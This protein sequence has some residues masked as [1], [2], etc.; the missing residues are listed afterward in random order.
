MLYHQQSSITYIQAKLKKIILK[1]ELSL[2]YCVSGTYPTLC[3]M[4]IY[5]AISPQGLPP[6]PHHLHHF[7]ALI[8]YRRKDPT[9]YRTAP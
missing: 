2:Y 6:L 4:Y 3:I 7:I 1:K 5:H 9:Y 8:L